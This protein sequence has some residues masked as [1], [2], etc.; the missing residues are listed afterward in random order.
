MMV[1][2]HNISYARTLSLSLSQS[3]SLSI[4]LGHYE[5]SSF[6]T[7]LLAPPAKNPI[8]WC[9]KVQ[10]ISEVS[11]LTEIRQQVISLWYTKPISL[12]SLTLYLSFI[13]VP[14]CIHVLALFCLT[15]CAHTML[16][17]ARTESGMN[18]CSSSAVLIISHHSFLRPCTSLL[19][20]RYSYPH[21]SASK[22]ALLRWLEWERTINVKQ[23]RHHDYTI[24][25]NGC[26]DYVI[27]NISINKRVDFFFSSRCWCCY[28]CCCYCCCWCCSFLFFFVRH[29]CRC[30]WFQ[31]LSNSPCVTTRTCL[32]CV[33]VF[34]RKQIVNIYQS[35]YGKVNLIVKY[36]NIC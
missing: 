19:H 36:T 13:L 28:C 26:L 5:F 2:L 16:R 4:S 34:G 15:Q 14:H 24:C 6:A 22:A 35:S 18:N 29:Y 3:L 11:L 20:A 31:F 25:S 9:Q 8:I 27:V 7:L 30:C 33:S 17:K 10:T 12:T 1:W 23:T 21:A 32:G